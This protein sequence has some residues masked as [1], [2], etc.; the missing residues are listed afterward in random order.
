MIYIKKTGFTL[1]EVLIVITV[2]GVVASLTIP[3]LIK[4]YRNQQFTSALKKEYSVIAQA[5]KLL[6]ADGIDM[7]NAWPGTDNGTA[8]LNIIAPKLRL[9]KNCGEELGCLHSTPLYNLDETTVAL[10]NCDLTYSNSHFGKAILIDGTMIIVQDLQANCND[11][12]G[13]GPLV[14]SVCGT[15]FV[16]VNGAK[17]PNAKGR[18]H[19]RFWVA[20]TGIYPFGANGD[21]MNLPF[22]DGCA[23]VVMLSGMNY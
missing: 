17:G 23:A 14:N 7:I 10:A 6:E 11:T 16:D 18:D 3:A 9:L 15:I 12:K 22:G 2:I 21:G 20:K 13:T 4:S 8:A 5:Y 1:A 19:F